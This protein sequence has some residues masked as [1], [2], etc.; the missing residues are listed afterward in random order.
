IAVLGVGPVIGIVID[1]VLLR[2]LHGASAATYVVVSLGLLVG[3]Q[4]LA[5]AIYGPATKSMDPF[6]SQDT[7]HLPGVNV[8]IEQTML[9]GIAL[10][11]A[12]ALGLFFR[13]TRL[14][15][16]TRAVVDDPSLTE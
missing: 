9:V 4:G 8:S 5:I 13:Y 11:S 14:G 6:F 3:L 2:R 16:Q 1:R 12:L 15:V 7:Y 10:A